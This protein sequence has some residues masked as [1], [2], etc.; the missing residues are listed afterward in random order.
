MVL[1]SEGNFKDDKFNGKQYYE[2]G[3]LYYEGDF[4]DGLRKWHKV[5]YENGKL[6]YEG[7]FKDGVQNGKGKNIMKMVS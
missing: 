3:K 6:N 7:D 5:Y 1:S 4:K 2:N